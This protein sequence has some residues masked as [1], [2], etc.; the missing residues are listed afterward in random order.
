MSNRPSNG[1]S[2]TSTTPSRRVDAL[3]YLGAAIS[4]IWASTYH[5]WL[6]DWI[7]GPVW[8]V[9]WVWGIPALWRLVRGQPVRPRRDG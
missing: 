2:S 6:L 3:L 4:Y 5:L 1:S 9:A 8:C 7:I